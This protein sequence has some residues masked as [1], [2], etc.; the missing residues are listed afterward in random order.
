MRWCASVETTAKSVSW[1]FP[2]P[3]KG[4]KLTTWKTIVTLEFNN[5]PFETVRATFQTN[6]AETAIFRAVKAA[7]KANPGRKPGSYSLTAEKQ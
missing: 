2:I 5:A 4:S 7:K 6:K 1:R 3:R